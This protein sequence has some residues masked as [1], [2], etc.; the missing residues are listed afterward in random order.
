MKFFHKLRKLNFSSTYVGYVCKLFEHVISIADSP[1]TLVISETAPNQQH[2]LTILMAAL[3]GFGVL[4]EFPLVIL[5]Y[6]FPPEKTQPMEEYSV[7][8]ATSW[9]VDARKRDHFVVSV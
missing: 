2:A 7:L 6:V 9:A 5:L 1:V 4:L 3:K 8:K